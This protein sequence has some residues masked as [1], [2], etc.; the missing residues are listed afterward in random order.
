MVESKAKAHTVAKIKVDESKYFLPQHFIALI[1]GVTSYDKPQSIVIEA[2]D[3]DGNSTSCNVQVT[4]KDTTY[5]TATC[6]SNTTVYLNNSGV[7]TVLPPQIGTGTDNCQISDLQINGQ[8]SF[9]YTCADVAV[10]TATL[11]VI[12]TEGNSSS[13]LAAITVVDSVSPVANCQANTIVQLDVNG[14]VTV[15][16]IDIDNGSTDAC[17]PLSYTVNGA[18]SQTFD[19]TSLNPVILEVTDAHGNTASCLT[20]VTTE[21]NIAPTASCHNPTVYLDNSGLAQITANDLNNGSFD[22]CQISGVYIDTIGTTTANF[23]CADAGVNN[24]MLIIEDVT[25][26]LDSCTATIT[27]EDTIAPLVTCQNASFDLTLTGNIGLSPADLNVSVSDACAI[28][29]IILSPDTITCQS[30]N[31]VTVRGIDAN[32]NIGLCTSQVAVTFDN[33]VPSTNSPDTLPLCEGSLLT[34]SANPPAGLTYAYEWSGPGGFV[35]TAQDTIV[36]T[37]AQA[38]HEGTYVVSITPVG[39]RGCPASASVVVGV[40]LVAPPVLGSNN[41]ICEGEDAVLTVLN[42]NDYT[43]N[44]INFDWFFNG[45]SLATTTATSLTINSTTLNDIGDYTVFVEV[46]GCQD[47]TVVPFSLNINPPPLA[48]MPTADTA[49]E[50]DTL[51]LVANPQ[52]PGPFIYAWENTTTGFASS[53]QNPILRNVDSA[54]A[55][56]YILRITDDSTCTNSATLDVVVLPNP[57]RPTMITNAPLCVSDILELTENTTYQAT[58][59]YNWVLPDNSSVITTAPQLLI[60]D[61]LAGDY[62]L[63]VNMNGCPSTADSTTVTYQ[64]VPVAFADAYTLE[65]RDSLLGFTVVA[66]DILDLYTVSILDSANNGTLLSSRVGTFNY[67]PDY[68]FFGIDTFTYTV[69][70]VNCPNSCDTTSVTLEV[71]TDFECFIPNAISPNGDGINDRLNIRCVNEYPNAEFRVFSR[72][73]NLVYEGPMNQWD[74]TFNGRNLPD[75]SYYYTLKLNDTT[76]IKNDRYTGYII[77]HR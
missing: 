43:G 13:C 54:D 56:Q 71:T 9:S 12:D 36:T 30:T 72:W 61:A 76:N 20:I 8:A 39:N 68:S 24:A 2:S 26:H 63:T 17:G 51:T 73:G 74:G 59:V 49:C 28:D 19:C 77:L 10:N 29:T 15:Q 37:D 33:P 53:L 11:T 34:L 31:V 48:P 23:T 70:D 3:A 14:Q 42:G 4:V 21:D 50:G 45:N 41:P 69:C 16:A 52:S 66:N 25:G 55:S 6:N 35:S 32:G 64:P 67:T 65:F 62:Q 47:S 44:V 22:N 46:D 5:P 75:G 38:I 40:Q 18:T 58:T 7:A 1:L 60:T 27:I 57:V